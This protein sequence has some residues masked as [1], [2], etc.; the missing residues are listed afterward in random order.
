MAARPGKSRTSTKGYPGQ[1]FSPGSPSGTPTGAKP[2]WTKPG[3]RDVIPRQTVN[4]SG[5][6][7][8]WRNGGLDG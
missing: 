8:L 3:A 2:S 1:P 7:N 5:R 6:N 4:G